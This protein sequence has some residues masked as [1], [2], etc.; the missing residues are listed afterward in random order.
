MMEKII[1]ILLVSGLFYA[2]THAQTK[3]GGY[4]ENIKGKEAF[5]K[6]DY[7]AAKNLFEQGAAKGD[8]SAL[9]N[10]GYL[11]QNGLG[12]AKNAT[13]ALSWY[14]KAAAKGHPVAY[15]NM[16]SLYLN[17]TEVK[18]D[19]AIAVD[20]FK[21]A[22]E[23]GYVPAATVLARLYESGR[24]VKQDYTEALRWYKMTGSDYETRAKK[25]ITLALAAKASGKQLV[26]SSVHNFKGAF[27]PGY[28]KI[29]LNAAYDFD[30]IYD[31]LQYTSV[32]YRIID[33]KTMRF[34]PISPT[35]SWNDDAILNTKSNGSYEDM[36]HM[37][38]YEPGTAPAPDSMRATS[39][40]ILKSVMTKMGN[41]DYITDGRFV[42]RLKD[43]S[44]IY[45][46]VANKI[47]KMNSDIELY[48]QPD[49]TSPVLEKYF[50][51]KGDF[52][53]HVEYGQGDKNGTFRPPWFSIA[54]SED[55][56]RAMCRHWG[57][58]EKFPV[59]DIPSKKKIGV[60]D[61][62]TLSGGDE[63]LKFTPDGDTL[64]VCRPDLMLCTKVAI[65]TGMR[66]DIHIPIKDLDE[67]SEEYGFNDYEQFAN[68]K[69]TRYP[70]VMD[71]TPDC[72]Q[73]LVATTNKVAIISMDG[74]PA[75]FISTPGINL[76]YVVAQRVYTEEVYRKFSATRT[77]LF[78]K[79]EEA[80]Y[81]RQQAERTER[82]QQY[83]QVKEASFLAE[84]ERMADYRKT[85]PNSRPGLTRQDMDNIIKT[86]SPSKAE[87][88]EAERH[89]KAMDDIYR[90]IE[91]EQK[92]FAEK[93]KE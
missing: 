82:E 67:N 22:A 13:M 49:A 6:K 92:K 43:G 8:S 19:T 51:M 54:I 53:A 74:S 81:R 42:S 36:V 29:V 65:R 11:Y 52:G 27:L 56:K 45:A 60:V 62:R 14:K 66:S 46:V 85:H 35:Y 75:K 90:S 58:G 38:A 78:N 87:Q 77:A 18:P 50:V 20:F 28:D 31:K 17:S 61:F 9:V 59:Y 79:V 41:Q 30:N 73:F 89:S 80:S 33:L 40:D 47:G 10:I 68:V 84:Q 4:D 2:N 15:H 48:R 7:T 72:K 93:W 63:L 86:N 1:L 88:Q 37:A 71:F 21:T 25:R 26:F 24:G 91:R 64:I 5:A 16:A 39:L 57:I 44:L 69:R 34:D 32:D 23:K 12:V 3:S 76:Q 83:A 55:G 70:F